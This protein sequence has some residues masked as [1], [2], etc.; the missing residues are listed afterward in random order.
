MPAYK[1]VHEV[2]LRDCEPSGIVF[3]P[4]Y[5]DMMHTVLENWLDEALDWPIS[6]VQGSDGLALPFVDVRA[7]FPA[8]SRLGDR[9]VWR[10]AIRDLRRSSMWLEFVGTT[11]AETRVSATGTLVLTEALALRT[12]RWPDTIVE[13][14]QD[15]LI[16]GNSSAEKV[17]E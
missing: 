16:P 6:Q 15:Y 7:E 2:M 12:R 13:R 9:L 8:P 1:Y 4:R 3:L 14:A 17:A 5:F 10:L 11:G